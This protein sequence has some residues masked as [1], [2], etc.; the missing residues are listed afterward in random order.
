MDD[1]DN[2]MEV[3]A[4]DTS[5]LA[6]PQADTQQTAPESVETDDA[7]SLTTPEPNT[8]PEPQA[9]PQVNWQERY[10]HLQS[11]ADRRIAQMR[12]QMQERETQ[13]G[14]L[15][16][17]REEQMKAAEAQNLKRWM[18]RH[19]EHKKFGTLLSKAK[20]IDAQ[21][22]ALPQ[23]MDPDTHA[24]AIEAITQAISPEERQELGAYRES[25]QEFQQNFF[26]DPVGSLMPLIGPQIKEMME[27]REAEV[28]AE[29]EV[30]QE[31]GD[32]A[33]APL[34]QRYAPEM[35]QALDNGVPYSYAVHMT[36]MFGELE[37]ARAELARMRGPVAQARAQT[38]AT[39]QRLTDTPSPRQPEVDVYTRAKAEAAKRGFTT[40]SPQFF[41]LL[42]TL[43]AQG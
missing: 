1:T 28:R 42:T 20:T 13:I 23:D 17:F 22:R 5:E 11:A 36:K 40:D 18:P 2:T 15:R 43:Q 34:V 12:T 3:D 41:K 30:Q 38:Q 35:K 32:P 19:P 6:P 10:S 37:A 33:L 29:Y 27:S 8:P 21:I 16:K 9:P 26:S 4:Q 25:V 39:R 24:R 31:L 14:E 7:S